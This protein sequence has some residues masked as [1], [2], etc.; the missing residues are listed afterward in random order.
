MTNEHSA[1]IKRGEFVWWTGVVEDKSDPLKLGRCKVRIFGWHPEQK[2]QMPTF[3]LPW[4]QVMLPTNNTEVYAPKNGDMVVGFFMD[5]SVGQQPVIMGVMP[6]IPL[7]QGNAEY[8]FS[9]SRTEEELLKSP[10]PPKEKEYKTDGTGIKLTEEDTAS[11]YPL[12]LDEPT[13]SRLARNDEDSIVKTFIEERK[14]N[15][16]KEVPVAEGE[17]WS[18]PETKYKTE[19]PWNN[20]MESESGHILEFDDTYEAERIHLAH[21]NGSFQEWFP[22]GDKVEK[23]TKDNY[24]IIMGNDKVYIMGKV[25]ITVQGD[26]D[27]YVKKSVQMKVDGSVTA[28]IGGDVKATIGGSVTADI[29]GDVTETVGGARNVNVSGDYNITAGNFKVSAGTINLN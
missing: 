27:V 25:N 23:V 7:T 20:A 6:A 18:E 8:P 16:V 9:D 3:N 24:T 1:E 14:K 4:S 10:R 29:S 12:N 26:A 11:L 15:V 19:Y 13:T 22:D 28:V 5:G 21:R 17:V 2:E